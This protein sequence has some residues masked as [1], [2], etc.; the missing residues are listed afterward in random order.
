MNRLATDLVALVPVAILVEAIAVEVEPV[1]IPVDVH[2]VQGTRRCNE[3]HSIHT[4]TL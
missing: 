4:T 1:A 3:R 2:G